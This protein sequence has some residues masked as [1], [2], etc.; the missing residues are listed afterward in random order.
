MDNK[1][2]ATKSM[3]RYADDGLLHCR[4]EKEAQELLNQLVERFKKIELEL[5]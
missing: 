2:Q 1:K 3:A 5:S 4:T